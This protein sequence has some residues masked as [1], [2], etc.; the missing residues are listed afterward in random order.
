MLN[1]P[2][3]IV[4]AVNLEALGDYRDWFTYGMQDE[5]GLGLDYSENSAHGDL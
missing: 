5:N 1:G 2:D 4:L 3:T